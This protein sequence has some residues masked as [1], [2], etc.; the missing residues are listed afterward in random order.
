MKEKSMVELWMD[1]REIITG[2][3]ALKK[4]RIHIDNRFLMAFLG[5]FLKIKSNPVRTDF[6]VVT[7][8]KEDWKYYQFPEPFKNNEEYLAIEFHDR[9]DDS[10]YDSVVIPISHFDA[11]L[12]GEDFVTR[13]DR[14]NAREK[15]E[16]EREERAQ[17]QKL[18]EKYGK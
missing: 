3:K 1:R 4:E 13:Q 9:N 8:E 12:T 7:V 16:R 15:E 5:A 18:K 2:I 6:K 17:Y 11:G 10:C 14:I